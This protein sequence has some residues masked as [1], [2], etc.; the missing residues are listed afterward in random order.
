MIRRILV[1]SFALGVI[2]ASTTLCNAQHGLAVQGP[3]QM[4]QR[5]TRKKRALI[6]ELL[7][8]VRVRKSAEE[9]IEVGVAQ[10]EKDLPALLLSTSASDTRTP[11]AQE[12]QEALNAYKPTAHRIATR[13]RQLVMSELNFPK[14]LEDA[15]Y[16][17]C[18]A[19]L[20]ESDLKNLIAFYHT[21]TGK[22]AI[23]LIPLLADEMASISHSIMPEIQRIMTE[24]FAGTEKP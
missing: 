2:F 17:I 8:I 6:K 1:F 9:F 13:Y 3:P 11:G 19:R 16:S 20:S 14:L 10:Y 22:K 12:R 15:C 5:V 23:G 24:A 21:P 18:A 4:P 7:E